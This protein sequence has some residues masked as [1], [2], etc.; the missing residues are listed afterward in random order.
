MLNIILLLQLIYS[1]NAEDGE[2]MPLSHWNK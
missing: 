1:I 2:L